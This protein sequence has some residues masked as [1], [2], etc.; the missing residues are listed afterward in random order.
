[1]K[2]KWIFDYILSFLLYFVI[3]NMAKEFSNNHFNN[4][5]IPIQP[6]KLQ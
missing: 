5:T 3:S 1:M 2:V 6:N 4:N